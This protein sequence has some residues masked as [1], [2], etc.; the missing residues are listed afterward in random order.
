MYACR[1]NDLLRESSLRYGEEAVRGISA[2]LRSTL[3]VVVGGLMLGAQWSQA[4]LPVRS[5]GLGVRDP[6]EERLT[7]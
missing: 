7:A 5:G 4:S 3:G 6:V 2:L 1:V